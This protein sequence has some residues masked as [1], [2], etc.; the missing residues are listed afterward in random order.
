[1]TAERIDGRALLNSG[2][3]SS[4]ID[5]EFVRRKQLTT[6]PAAVVRTV[7]NTDRSV[8]RFSKEYV[9]L[10]IKIRDA[11]GQEHVEKHDFPVANLSGKQ[12]LFLRYDWLVDHNP[13]IDWQKASI[14]FS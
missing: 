3:T 11:D 14:T 8:N 9:E 5:R 7:Y 1:D 13:E 4:S 6:Q 12:D 2:C 10:L